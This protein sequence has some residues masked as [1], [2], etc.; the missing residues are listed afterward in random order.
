MKLYE[1]QSPTLVHK[2]NQDYCQINLQQ[3]VNNNNNNNNNNN[4]LD[5]YIESIGTAIY[6]KKR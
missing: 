6:S 2:S 1:T 4:I 5:L 3:T